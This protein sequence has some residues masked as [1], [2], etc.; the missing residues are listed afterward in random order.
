MT[1][2][3]L[4]DLQE[5]YDNTEVGKTYLFT[6]QVFFDSFH[7]KKY[8]VLDKTKL[9]DYTYRYFCQCPET[10]GVIYK[11]ALRN[12]SMSIKDRVVDIKEVL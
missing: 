9:D 1:K 8:I 5:L 6:D 10:K 11:W 4:E 12:W 7:T 2:P 3:S